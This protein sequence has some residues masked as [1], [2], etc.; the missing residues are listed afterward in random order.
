M[1]VILEF[2]ELLHWLFQLKISKINLDTLI[3]K[4]EFI[5]S[6]NQKKVQIW[7]RIQGLKFPSLFFSIRFMIGQAFSLVSLGLVPVSPVTHACIDQLF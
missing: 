1:Y 4:G 6:W 5:N 3:H 2:S 7:S